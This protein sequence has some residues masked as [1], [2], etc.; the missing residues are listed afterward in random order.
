M[1]LCYLNHTFL[2]SPSIPS[3]LIKNITSIKMIL[4]ILTILMYMLGDNIVKKIVIKMLLNK[5]VICKR[6][7]SDLCIEILDRKMN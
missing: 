1:I 6:K 5:I 2:H 3:L 4:N 7:Y